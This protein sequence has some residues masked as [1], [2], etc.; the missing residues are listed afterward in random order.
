MSGT[1]TSGF[2]DQNQL[3]QVA[4][5]QLANYYAPERNRLLNA[6]AQQT[7]DTGRQTQALN[8]MDM[9]GRASQGLLNLGDEQSRAAAYPGIVQQLQGMGFAKNAPPTYPGETA[10]KQL[11]AQ[12]MSVPDQFKTGF[13]TPPGMMDAIAKSNAPLGMPG[14]TAGT[15]TAAPTGFNG[16]LA[17]AESGGKSNAINP[18]GY[19]GT[20]QFGKQRLAQLGYYTPAPGEDMSDNTKWGGK[21]SVPGFNV[22]DQQSFA[23]NPAAQQVVFNTH[24]GDID[25]AIT[26]TPGA[27]RFD[28]NGLRA[29]AHLGGVGGMQR[30]VSSGGTYNPAD[31]NGTTL[32]AYYQ[33]FSGGGGAP[34]T[35]TTAAT[36]PASG[37][38]TVAVQGP[39]GGVAARTGGTDVAGPG[40]GATA[41]PP[42][43]GATTAPPTAPAPPVVQNPLGPPVPPIAAPGPPSSTGGPPPQPPTGLQ[44]SQVQAALELQRR[45]AALEAQYP[46][47]PQ[48]KAQAAAL[49]LQAQTLAQAD[50]MQETTRAGLQGDVN[51]RTNE[52]KPYPAQRTTTLKDGTQDGQLGQR[53][54]R[55]QEFKPCGA[56]RSK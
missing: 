6:Q 33:R 54:T 8:E 29:V 38:T 44:S 49:R 52:F 42:A 27:D 20:Y 40:A 15:G 45:A 55:T 51:L 35:Q 7:L 31:A 11:V 13:A 3:M 41:S 14:P 56:R 50:V 9:M 48:V 5:Q 19:T 16:A 26:N 10:L 36:P 23:N 18:Q 47:S 24:L 32:G 22:T 37:A 21:V 2:P 30:F 43:V 17:T 53:N 46:F 28:K 25:N 34:G 1:Q 39:G 4:T 12:S